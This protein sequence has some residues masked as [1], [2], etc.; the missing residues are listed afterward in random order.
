MSLLY[1][2]TINEKLCKP[3]DEELC[4]RSV[5]TLSSSVTFENYNKL[6]T[7][8]VLDSS[9]VLL[10]IETTSTHSGIVYYDIYNSG[11]TVLTEKIQ[12]Y[13]ENHFNIKN[14]SV[15]NTMTALRKAYTLVGSSSITIKMGSVK[16]TSIKPLKTPLAVNVV[17]HYIKVPSKYD[18]YV[19]F[20][21]RSVNAPKTDLSDNSIT[22]F[23]K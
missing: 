6:R 8:V 12:T 10:G 11:R 17:L 7:V 23:G 22:M 15:S 19:S 13:N 2:Y 9:I 4:E 14:K 21:N 18:A 3:L 5:K 1:G 20:A 16:F